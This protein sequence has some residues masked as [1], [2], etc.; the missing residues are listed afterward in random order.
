M[1]NSLHFKILYY[2][3]LFFPFLIISLFLSITSCNK[4]NVVED[5]IVEEE[6][7]EEP[8]N[9]LKIYIPKE[10]ASTGFES[11]A[12]KWSYKRSKES[13]HFILFWE[14]GY[15]D[16]SP[17]DSKVA[18]EY[19]VDIDN[20][21]KKAEEFYKLNVE[22]LK[23]AVKGANTSKLETYKMMIFLHH[24]KDWMA[25]GGGYDDVIGALWISPNTCQPVGATI[26][27]EIGHS[28]QYQVRCDLGANHGFRYG[29][30]STDGNG[31]WEQ[32]AQWQAMQSYPDEIFTSHHF[33]VYIDNHHRH[34]IHEDYR[35][36][37]YFIHYYWVN[38]HTDK[39]ISR[40][41][42]ESVRPE[43]PIQAY[44]RLTNINTQQVNAEIY[45]MASKFATWDLDAL[46]A[47]GKD[48]IGR[49]TNKFDI[50]A[51]GSLRIK[52]E[53][54]LGTTGFNII[55]L[56]VPKSQQEV[57]VDFEGIVNTVGYNTVQN[58]NRA[59]WRYG[60]VALLQSG[61]R[62]YSPM[63]EAI[64]ASKTFV[65]PAQCEKLFFIVTGAP[66]SYMAH[67]WDDNERNDDQ[68][69][70]Q[71]KVTGTDVVGYPTIDE[72][73]EPKDVTFNYNLDIPFSN[74]SYAGATIAI[75]QSA[76]AKAFVLQVDAL[77][78]AIGTTI[79]FYA[80]EANGNLNSNNTAQGLG[81]WF[82]AEGNVVNWGALAR[83]YAEFNKETLMF[84]IG[85]YPNQTK[86]GD[87]F[88]I[89]Q[90]LQYVA[91]N[92]RKVNA[93]FVFNIKMIK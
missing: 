60:F 50:Q 17:A 79:Q 21:L 80:V 57:K 69:P 3:K 27:H 62:V 42:R 58:A 36:A 18:E 61:E 49:Q 44:M 92:G 72:S 84:S 38:K 22:Q 81:H 93:L 28:F 35:Y 66:N 7:S 19:R 23:F 39:I 71:I 51:D 13:E 54:C 26:A 33:P 73:Q 29:F 63:Y 75:D 16:L 56:D 90:M 89:R 41:W 37:N 65:V 91:N 1:L 2:Q 88:T 31:F 24:T 12:N 45:D 48:F 86:V 64:K 5:P 76:L 87:Q 46:R 20:L 55:R 52:Y 67:S 77:K 40:I 78:S 82:T 74:T 47:R 34:Q 53:Q 32:T 10:F 59:G 30:G 14:S 68:W 9:G 25:Y 85:Q 11:N 43:D 8:V 70:Y 6:P 4:N 15:G 83:V